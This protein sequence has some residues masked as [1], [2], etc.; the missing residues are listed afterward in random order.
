[1][2]KLNPTLYD[3]L[4]VGADANGQMQIGGTYATGGDMTYA[5]AGEGVTLTVAKPFA[6]SVYGDDNNTAL[7]TGWTSTIFG[8]NILFHAITSGNISAFGVSGQ[9]HIG[10]SM[11]VTGN[12]GGVYGCVETDETVTLAA[13]TFGG[14]F[15]ATIPSTVTG[16]DS[17]WMGGI[18]IGGT[19]D[20]GT[21]TNNYVGIYFQNPG[22]NVAYDGIFG[23]DS[24]QTTADTLTTPSYHI[25]VRCNHSGVKS[26]QYI[27]LY[28]T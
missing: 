15:G 24:A 21:T 5:S 11:A 28:S 9:L 2:A 19:N 17:Y 7:T 14:V 23:F 26:T 25:P 8:S 4:A 16:N 6:I 13:N 27:Q 3:G 10:A 18:L 20:G 22:S 1:M 12:L